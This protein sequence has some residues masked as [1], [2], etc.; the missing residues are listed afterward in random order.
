MGHCESPERETHDPF[1]TETPPDRRQARRSHTEPGHGGR[2]GS[3]RNRSQRPRELHPTE[4]CQKSRCLSD[5]GRVARSRSQPTS[6]R[7][8]GARDGRYRTPGFPESWQSYLREVFHRFREML[9]RHPNIAPLIGTQLVAN[10]GVDLD[11]IERVARR[12]GSRG[13]LRVARLVAAVQRRRGRDGSVSRPRSWR[14]SAKDTKPWQKE[15]P[16]ALERRPG[17]PPPHLASDMKLLANKAFDPPLGERQ[18][19]PVGGVVR[20]FVDIVITGLEQLARGSLH[21]AASFYPTVT[22][23]MVS[24]PSVQATMGSG[25]MPFR[26]LPT[27]RI[28]FRQPSQNAP[29]LQMRI[30]RVERRS[31]YVPVADGTRLAVD[32]FLPQDLAPTKRLP[33]LYTATRYWR[34]MDGHPIDPSQKEWIARRLRRRERRCAWHRRL[35]GQWY[36]PYRN[37]GSQRPRLSRHLDRQTILVQRQCGHDRKLLSGHDPVDGRRLRCARHQGNRA[38]V[39]R[40]RCLHR[41]AFPG[42]RLERLPSPSNGEDSYMR[43][44]RTNFRLTRRT[45]AR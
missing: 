42:G 4:P 35:L 19:C 41:P 22:T 45:R 33:T 10:R 3:V 43:W 31:I 32:I 38:E 24:G 5:R 7:G 8:R 28:S 27:L 30:P 2:R 21:G 25:A 11:F 6:R 29:C 12:P 1:H 36:I 37:P 9:R 44:I 26:Y 20:M 15:D 14:L 16:R 34:G 39:F 13:F 18:R 40:F 23:N 17:L